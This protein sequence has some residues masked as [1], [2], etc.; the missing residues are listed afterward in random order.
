MN[1]NSLEYVKECTEQIRQTSCR[2]RTYY[3]F[4]DE[5]ELYCTWPLSMEKIPMHVR[6]QT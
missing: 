2:V 1:Q 6:V 5:L 4:G 3:I